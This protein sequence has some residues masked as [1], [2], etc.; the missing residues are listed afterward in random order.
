M[1]LVI[2]VSLKI[3]QQAMRVKKKIRTH[4][5]TRAYFRVQHKK[6]FGRQH[7]E[8]FS[9]TKI[10][11][12]KIKNKKIRLK[13]SEKMCSVMLDV[14]QVHFLPSPPCL[15]SG[16]S[17]P[18]GDPKKGSEGRTGGCIF[19]QFRMQCRHRLAHMKA[20]AFLLSP[21]FLLQGPVTAA[22]HHP[23]RTKD[24]SHSLLL[25]A[26]GISKEILPH[27]LFSCLHLCK[28]SFQ[29]ILLIPHW[30]YAL[31]S[32]G[33]SLTCH[34]FTL[35][36]LSITI[37]IK[38]I[39]AFDV[40]HYPYTKLQSAMFSVNQLVHSSIGLPS[41]LPLSYLLRVLLTPFM[42][43]LA[44]PSSLWFVSL[45]MSA[46]GLQVYLSHQRMGGRRGQEHFKE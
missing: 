1:D 9:I 14:F 8:N 31:L 28:Q 2:Y 17:P 25:L 33:S 7:I 10:Q 20:T 34:S 26:S 21:H 5:C 23:F 39:K 36:L 16:W 37:S 19:P 12:K 6:V 3:S 27:S 42:S 32:S 11:Y 22:S 30:V 45:E 18:M 4:S 41:F 15:S 44:Y 29:S 38:Y 24:S 40:H 35:P 43:T 46:N 13:Q